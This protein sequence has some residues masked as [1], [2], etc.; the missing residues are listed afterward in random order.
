VSLLTETNVSSGPASAVA[1]ANSLNGIGAIE[2][3]PSRVNRSTW[4]RLKTS[5]KPK[6]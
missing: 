6:T 1:W 5:G 4:S 2:P 3:M